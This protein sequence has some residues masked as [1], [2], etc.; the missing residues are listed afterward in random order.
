MPPLERSSSVELFGRAQRLALELGLPALAEAE[1]GGGSDGS[2]I[3]ALGIPTLD[4]LGAVGDHAHGE[5]EFVHVDAMAER[6]A[7]VAAL[8]ADLLG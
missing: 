1:V 7:L 3:A 5:G 6:A 4:G 2:V 8:V